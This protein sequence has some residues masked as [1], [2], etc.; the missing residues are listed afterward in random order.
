MFAKLMLHILHRVTR[1]RRLK[2]RTIRLE[3]E[4]WPP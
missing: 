2:I 3:D 4:V 1:R